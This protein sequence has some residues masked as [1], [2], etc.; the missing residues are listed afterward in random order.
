VTCRF[1]SPP[2]PVRPPASTHLLFGLAHWE[3]AVPAALVKSLVPSPSVLPFPG[4]PDWLAGLLNSSTPI[5]PAIDL[6]MRLGIGTAKTPGT[7]IVM[8]LLADWSGK[9]T[10]ALLADR[11]L[12]TASIRVS[13]VQPIRGSNPPPFR[14]FIRGAWRGRSRACYLL[15]MEKVIPADLPDHLQTIFS[16]LR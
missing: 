13:E 7:A 10:V 1:S 14:K 6:R 3:F 11:I 4:M 12:H 16:S 8:E 9:S 2:A 15:D 5:T